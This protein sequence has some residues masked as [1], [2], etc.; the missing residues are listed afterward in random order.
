MASVCSLGSVMV[1]YQY[2][3]RWLCHAIYEGS[4][5]TTAEST[6]QHDVGTDTCAD[7]AATCSLV[8]WQGAALLHST[9]DCWQ[10][11]RSFPG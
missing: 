1:L 10:G 6:G 5:Y 2:S 11:S 7:P 3:A 9:E 8:L 4:A